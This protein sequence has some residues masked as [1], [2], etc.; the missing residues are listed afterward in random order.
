MKQCKQEKFQL[1]IQNG[2]AYQVGQS[3]VL[4]PGLLKF[5]MFNLYV[6]R[7]CPCK[8][9]AAKG[10]TTDCLLTVKLCS[11]LANR[12][13]TWNHKAFYVQSHLTYWLPLYWFSNKELVISTE[14]F[15]FW[16]RSPVSKNNRNVTNCK[17]LEKGRKKYSTPKYDIFLWI[18][19]PSKA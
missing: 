1:L 19:L 8:H 11:A 3:E 15:I 4:P 13:G 18:A 14:K 12:C 16:S 17:Q 7:D 5:S 9:A 6:P 2:L 10:V